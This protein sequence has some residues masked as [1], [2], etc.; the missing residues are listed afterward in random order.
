[1]KR[2]SVQSSPPLAENDLQNHHDL[3]GVI[4]SQL[5]A[6]TPETSRR[7]IQKCKRWAQ[8]A[9]AGHQLAAHHDATSALKQH[10]LLPDP[11]LMAPMSQFHEGGRPDN[12][13][14]STDHDGIDLS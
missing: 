7:W 1:M 12:L 14:N 3:E 13:D 8:V 10:G 6:I 2:S 5:N 4:Q 11:N 9:R